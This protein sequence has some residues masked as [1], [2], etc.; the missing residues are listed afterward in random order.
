MVNISKP[1]IGILGVPLHD[2]KRNNVI[3]LFSDYKNAVIKK[4]RIPFML[5]PILNIMELN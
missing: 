1:I 3:A 4:D 2:D 5:S